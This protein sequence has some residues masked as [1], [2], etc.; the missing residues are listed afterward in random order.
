MWLTV[1][2]EHFA[3]HLTARLPAAIL[4]PSQLGG[5]TMMNL[6]R[7]A[8]LMLCVCSSA[9]LA[10]DVINQD[11]RK[12]TIK[13]QGEGKL[14]ISN[15][16]VGAGGSM[17]GLCGYSFCTFEIP[18]SKATANKNGKLFIRGGKFVR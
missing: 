9:A 13:V 2:R 5:M 3:R 8:G 14:S 18:G 16:T 10:T 12:Y 6:N 4:N 17:Y 15:H 11:Q 1:R 7:L